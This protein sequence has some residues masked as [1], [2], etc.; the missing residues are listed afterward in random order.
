MSEYGG[1][2]KADDTFCVQALRDKGIDDTNP[3]IG[4]SVRQVL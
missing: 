1:H 3:T 2:S 4:L